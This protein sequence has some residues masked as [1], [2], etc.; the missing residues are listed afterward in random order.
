[1]TTPHDAARSAVLRLLRVGVAVETL[2]T[3]AEQLRD[4][5][6]EIASTTDLAAWLD[7]RADTLAAA[8]P[9]GSEVHA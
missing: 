9:V 8:S 3:A 7:H 4:D 6:A 1:M 2:R 5:P